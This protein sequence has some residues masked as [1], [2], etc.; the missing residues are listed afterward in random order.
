MLNA[1]LWWLVLLILG[2]ATLPITTAVFRFLPDRGY[3]FNRPLGLLL[4]SYVFWVCGLT[5]LLPNAVRDILRSALETGA[6]QRAAVDPKLL[7][8]LEA[9]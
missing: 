2:L 7:A 6:V 9:Q 3:A 4:T 5:G 8:D 1:L